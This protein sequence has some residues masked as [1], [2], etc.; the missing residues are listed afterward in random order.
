M[1]TETRTR[2]FPA[3]RTEAQRRRDKDVSREEQGD[4]DTC[5]KGTTMM[6]GEEGQTCKTPKW[7]NSVVGSRQG[8]SVVGSVSGSI[9]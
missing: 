1:T 4:T 3:D 2:G 6:Y 9:G 5:G 8:N 7:Q